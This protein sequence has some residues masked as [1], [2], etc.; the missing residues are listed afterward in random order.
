VSG[1]SSDLLELSIAELAGAL[2]SRRASSREATDAALARIAA[3]DDRVGAFLTVTAERARAQ[4]AAADDR[5]A[6][7]ERRGPLDGVPLALKDIFLTKGVETT[8]ASRILQGF[9][10]PYDATVVERLEAAGAVLLGKLNMD[11]FAMGSSNENSAFKPCHNPWDLAR[12]PGGSSGGSAAAVSARQAFGALGTDTGGSIREPA[13]FCGVVGLKPTYGRVSR[14]GV[15]AFASSL[16]QVG[17]I[18]RTVRD[19]AEL[20]QVVAGHDERDMTSSTRPVGDY[21]AAL[22]DGAR[23]LRVGVVREWLEGGVES[24]VARRIE[25]ALQSYRAMGAEIV[26]VSL[27]HTRYGIAAYYLIAP[28]EAS[29]N[30]ARYDGVRFGPRAQGAGG[31][32][33][34]YGETRRQ[35]FGAEPKRRIML[36][37]YALSAGYYDAYYLRAQKVRTLLRRDFDRA[38]ERC[39]VL[40]GPVTPTVAFRLGDKV[41]DPLQMYL[42]DVFTVTCNLAALPGMSVPCGVHPAELVPVGLQLVGRPFDEA[43]MLRAARALEREIGPLPAPPIGAAAPGGSTELTASGPRGGR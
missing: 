38:F 34:M 22:E 16:D 21:G 37:T 42:A 29:S 43:T 2:A 4:A 3:T 39:D 30:L 40:A 14:Y 9:V 12:T 35:G 20:L 31:L 8:C 10:P 13:A 6:R 15:I 17:P 25:E 32:R 27:P 24:G 11:E 41:D 1:G 7:G 36:G 18:G 19:V 33:E 28:A 23:G 5:A 26:E